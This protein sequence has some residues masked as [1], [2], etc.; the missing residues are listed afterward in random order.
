[1]YLFDACFGHGQLYVAASRVGRRSHLRFA[2]E[3][4]EAGAYRTANVV[5]REALS[6]VAAADARAAPV[7]YDD[8]G[9][10]TSDGAPL[11]SSGDG[12]GGSSGMHIDVCAR[13]TQC[14]AIDP[15]TLL[16][17]PCEADVDATET[18]DDAEP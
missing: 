14:S 18:D 7:E 10:E 2:V 1:M 13:C 9:E 8:A 15:H 16:C 3:R 17:V 4:D 6:D 11:P 12:A 5:Y